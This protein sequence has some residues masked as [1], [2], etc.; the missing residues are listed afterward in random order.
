MFCRVIGKTE[1]RSILDLLQDLISIN[2]RKMEREQADDAFARSG[3][4]SG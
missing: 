2:F 3:T 4:F 1:D